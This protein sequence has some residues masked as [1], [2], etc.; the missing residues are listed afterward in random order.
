[1]AQG[2]ATD[3]YT[4][5][6]VKLLSSVLLVKVKDKHITGIIINMLYC[7]EFSLNQ[8]KLKELDNHHGVDSTGIL[9]DK[10]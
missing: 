7:V 1:M 6:N 2:G 4:E 8:T 10:S 5:K 9:F 3:E